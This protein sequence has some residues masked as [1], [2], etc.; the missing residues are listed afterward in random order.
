[1]TEPVIN[2]MCH[3]HG[4][5][6]APAAA[7]S[8]RLCASCLVDGCEA[9]RPLPESRN[10]VSA[11]EAVQGM[12][13]VRRGSEVVIGQHDVLVLVADRE[14]GPDEARQMFAG[15]PEQLAGRVLVVPKG[16]TIDV[17]RDLLAPDPRC[18]STHF[19]PDLGVT[20]RC[21]LTLDEHLAMEAKHGGQRRHIEPLPEGDERDPWAIPGMHVWWD[22]PWDD[23]PR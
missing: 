16:W 18:P 1:M 19:F 10:V 3:A 13:L 15:L 7:R 22:P 11:G 17:A 23:P 5:G 12:S 8:V 6:H 21:A 14:L 4:V 2:C 9:D 20:L